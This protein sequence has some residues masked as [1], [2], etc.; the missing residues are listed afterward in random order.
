MENKEYIEKWLNNTLNDEERAEF[1]QSEDYNSL[2]KL[3]VALANFKAPEFDVKAEREKLNLTKEKAG[4]VIKMSWLQPLM[5][6]A[7]VLAIVLL[8]YI[9]WFYNPTTTINTGIAEKT[10]ISL[11]D[12]STVVLNALSSIAYST[13]TWKKKRQLRLAG[14]AFFK[15]AKGSRFTV[16]TEHGNVVVLGTQFSVNIRDEYFEVICYEGSVSVEY[17]ENK[18]KLSPQDMFRVIG[19]EN[20]TQSNI[21]DLSPA[22]LMDE[23]AFISTPVKYVIKELERQ[24]DVSVSTEKVDMNQ[25]FTGRFTHN[26][27]DLALKTFCIPLSL[28]YEMKG[29]KLIFLTVDT[30]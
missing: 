11:P 24:Y 27:L 7:A 2:I 10:E 1:M 26:N 3:D 13:A 29:N 21:N 14:N 15:V 25:L 28:E 20:Y 22:W 19:S 9:F 17:Q 16:E 18:I 12:E 4:R 5:K 8:G 6:V 30:Q 23:S